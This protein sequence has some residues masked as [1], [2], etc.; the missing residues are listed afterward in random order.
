MPQLLTMVAAIVAAAGD[1]PAAAA[2]TG[3]E[4]PAWLQGAVDAYGAIA[5]FGAFVVSGVGLHLS[6]DL[7]LIRVR[8]E[9]SPW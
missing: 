5:L 6:E 9:H 3:Q 8:P 4:L 7:I 1:A 2:A